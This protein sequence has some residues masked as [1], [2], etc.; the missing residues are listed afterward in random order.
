MNNFY[1]YNYDATMN[2]EKYHL[3]IHISKYARKNR[4][5]GTKS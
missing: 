4:C 1:T 3:D 2:V 5:Y